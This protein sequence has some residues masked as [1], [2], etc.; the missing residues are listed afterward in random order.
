MTRRGMKS[1]VSN[2]KGCGRGDERRDDERTGH[3]TI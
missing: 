1:A 3:D 2:G